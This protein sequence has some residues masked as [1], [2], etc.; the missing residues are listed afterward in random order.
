[1]KIIDLGTLWRDI[2][3]YGMPIVLYCG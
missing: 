2:M 3:H 1:M